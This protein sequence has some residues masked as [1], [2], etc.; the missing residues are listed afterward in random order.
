MM[1]SHRKIT[2]DAPKSSCC[3]D[4]C[5]DCFECPPVTQKV[6]DRFGVVSHGSSQAV[7]LVYKAWAIKE[8]VVNCLVSE[9]A[10]GAD[11]GLS[12]INL[13]Q[14]MIKRDMSRA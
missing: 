14:K 9:L 1:R 12:L 11:W 6:S 10:G 5:K 4:I 13:M 2:V 3:T 7:P 8:I